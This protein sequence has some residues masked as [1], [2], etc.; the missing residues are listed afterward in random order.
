MTMKRLHTRVRVAVSAAALVGG[1]LLG[2]A[3]PAIAQPTAQNRVADA[4]PQSARASASSTGSH[5]RGHEVECDGSDG[6]R[7]Y[8]RVE[9]GSIDVTPASE[10]AAADHW[11]VDQLREAAAARRWYLDQTREAAAA[12]RW[13]VDQLVAAQPSA[14]RGV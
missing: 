3:G 1:V 9:G 13:Y 6:V 11:Y 8:D 7:L 10:A 5:P 14:H 12:S 2:S 4:I